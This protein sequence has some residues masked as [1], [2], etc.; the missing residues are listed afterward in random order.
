M[1]RMKHIPRSYLIHLL[2]IYFL[3]TINS[4]FTV[5]GNWQ[6]VLYAALLLTFITIFIKPLLKILF[7][8]INM[9]TLGF[10]AWVINIGILYVLI[11]IAPQ[12]KIDIW[13]FPGTSGAFFSIPAFTLSKPANFVVS[14]LLL[15]LV[16][17]AL[18][19]L[20]D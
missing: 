13:N 18:R 2:A 16:I 4:G 3:V 14:A 6:A 11:L 17:R 15:A 8:P 9:I 10:F 1:G 12:I 19:W 20:C 5:A 7:L